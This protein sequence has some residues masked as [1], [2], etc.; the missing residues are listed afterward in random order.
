[1]ANVADGCTTPALV[2]A[3]RATERRSC[4]R[5]GPSPQSWP[6]GGDAARDARRPT[7]T[8]A[9]PPL[10]PRPAPLSEVAG[11]QAAV[12]I[13]HVA[14]GP[15]SLVVAPVAPHEVDAVT[16]RS[17]LA[18]VAEEEKAREGAEVKLLEDEVDKESQQLEELVKV[19][20]RS[21]RRPWATLFG[22]EEAAVHW[23]VAMEKAR[24]K[25][26]GEEEEEEEAQLLLMVPRRFSPHF[27]RAPCIWQ[28]CSV[29][30]YCL[31]ST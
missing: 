3:T 10:G 22:S 23:H 18:R 14:A 24:K 28:F 4:P 8:P 5:H 11:P 16:V 15:P 2:V 27:V 21:H 30:W 9:S 20:D 19:R 29:S 6:C 25:K 13:G 31:K 26:K 17:F 7:D 12:T 1:M